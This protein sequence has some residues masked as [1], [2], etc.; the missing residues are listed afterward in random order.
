VLVDP[1]TPLLGMCGPYLMLVH[2]AAFRRVLSLRGCARGA[3]VNV[4]R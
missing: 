3:G 4:G 2:G 1:Y